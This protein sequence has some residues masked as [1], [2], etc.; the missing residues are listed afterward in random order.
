MNRDATSDTAAETTKNHLLIVEVE[1]CSA[2]C[3]FWD[4]LFGGRYC[5]HPALGKAGHAV[6]FCPQKDNEPPSWCPLRLEPVLYVLG[7]ADG[8]LGGE[9]VSLR[10]ER[11]L[12]DDAHRRLCAT[13]GERNRQ[14][15]HREDEV[16]RSQ[17]LLEKCEA[18]LKMTQRNLWSTAAELCSKQ[19][20]VDS[21]PRASASPLLETCELCGREREC[22]SLLHVAWFTETGVTP[23]VCSTCRDALPMTLRAQALMFEAAREVCSYDWAGLPQEAMAAGYAEAVDAIAAL[24]DTLTRV[25]PPSAAVGSGPPKPPLGCSYHRYSS[26]TCERG[27]DGCDVRHEPHYGASSTGEPRAFVANLQ[28]DFAAELDQ[29]RAQQESPGGQQV[30]PSEYSGMPHSLLRMLERDCRHALGRT[31]KPAAPAPCAA[32]EVCEAVEAWQTAVAAV[33]RVAAAGRPATQEL[34]VVIEERLRCD[35]MKSDLRTA[36]LRDESEVRAEERERRAT[37]PKAVRECLA[38]LHDL[39]METRGSIGSFDAA[40]NAAASTYLC[41]EEAVNSWLGKEEDDGDEATT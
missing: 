29:R 20:A 6:H 4:R 36:R 24:G 35:A 18:Q 5:N 32:A 21:E 27:T 9:V 40:A 26:R 7:S 10:A 1:E 22:F 19:L 11:D 34:P 41:Y 16:R 38:A 8:V 13:I 12:Y 23:L 14:L 30:G 3:P 25:P 2:W 39:A 15:E 33:E 31:G 17:S 28:R 37:P